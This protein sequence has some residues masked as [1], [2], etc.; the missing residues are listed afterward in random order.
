MPLNRPI[1]Y[2]KKCTS[3]L[4]VQQFDSW[5]QTHPLCFWK[6]QTFFHIFYLPKSVT[7]FPPRNSPTTFSRKYKYSGRQA[8]FVITERSS[9]FCVRFSE[10]VTLWFCHFYPLDGAP[11]LAYNRC[12]FPMANSRRQVCS[13]AFSIQ[14]QSYIELEEKLW[15][16]V[17]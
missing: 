10:E 15:A 11:C 7:R 5:N 8:Q 1:G 2:F 17:K 14:V 6:L 9:R 13:N 3:L 12:S 16:D 4:T